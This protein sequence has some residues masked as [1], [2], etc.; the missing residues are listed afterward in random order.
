MARNRQVYFVIDLANTTLERFK[1][2]CS[3]SEPG[4]LPFGEALAKEKV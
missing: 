2:N 4:V 3:R 1:K